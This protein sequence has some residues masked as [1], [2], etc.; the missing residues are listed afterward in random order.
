[1]SIEDQPKSVET[2][3]W[4]VYRLRAING[5]WQPQRPTGALL[6]GNGG[7]PAERMQRLTGALPHGNGGCPAERMQ[8]LTGALLQLLIAPV[9]FGLVLQQRQVKVKVAEIRQTGVQKI[10]VLSLTLHG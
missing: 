8:R 10:G 5:P 4:G 9:Y 1:M 7:C 6:H 3:R 2:P